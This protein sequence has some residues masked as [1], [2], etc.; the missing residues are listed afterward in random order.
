MRYTPQQN[1]AAL[2]KA[3]KTK[4]INCGQ[5]LR[6]S[7]FLALFEDVGAKVYPSATYCSAGVEHNFS[8]NPLV[9][10]DYC[11]C[12]NCTKENQHSSD[13][14]LHNMPAYPNGPCDCGAVL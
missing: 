7:M 2:S 9:D 10:L 11:G 12:G 14:S 13:C 3:E 1:E 5:S 8:E 6:R 4:C